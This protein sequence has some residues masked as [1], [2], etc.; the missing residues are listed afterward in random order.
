MRTHG[1]A[2]HLTAGLLVPASREDE[3]LGMGG[4]PV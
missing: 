3:G 4:Q 2:V 1:T